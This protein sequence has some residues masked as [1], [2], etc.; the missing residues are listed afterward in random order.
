MFLVDRHRYSIVDLVYEFSSY[1]HVDSEID[2]H[3]DH[4]HCLSHRPTNDQ[5][6]SDQS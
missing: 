5:H 4:H 1:Q 3:F 2:L 6:V